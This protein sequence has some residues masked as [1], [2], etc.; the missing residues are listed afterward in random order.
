M[1][2]NDHKLLEK[3][4]SDGIEARKSI[5]VS[6][7]I[8]VSEILFDRLKKGG[9]LITFGNGGSAADAQHFVAELS[10]RFMKERKSF[11][12]VALTTN[13]SSL[14]AIGNDYDF[15]KVFSRQL[16]GICAKED[17]VVG[18][19]TSGNS[20]NVIEGIRTA[21]KIGAFTLALT[22]RDGGKVRNEADRCI[23]VNSDVTPL[24]Q[25]VH[26]AIIHM[27]PIRDLWR[28]Q[29]EVTPI[30]AIARDF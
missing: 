16:E 9:K 4:V 6:A 8:T 18:I 13:S 11:P 10:G 17:F 28:S 5:E 25:E 27:I 30:M 19:S 15:S 26:I 22:G 1:L 20:P 23:R 12:A 14:T 29:G 2:E 24:I 3:Y 7:I 21:R